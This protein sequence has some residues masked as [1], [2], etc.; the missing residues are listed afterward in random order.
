MNRARKLS[1]VQ[2]V[3]LEAM[4]MGLLA[5]DLKEFLAIS[6]SMAQSFGFLQSRLK[7]EFPKDCRKCGKVYP[8][9]EEF[10]FGT[11]E[12][13]RGTVHYPTLGAE[14]FLHRNCKSPCESTLVAVF[15]DRR[16]D[17]PSGCKRRDI[18]ES[19]LDRLQDKMPLQPA[20]LREFLLGLLIKK[21][22]LME[23]EKQKDAVTV[24]AKPKPG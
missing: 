12:I 20:A 19:C 22:H 23:K 21:I 7:S 17:S 3:D 13:E 1:N 18:F 9:F 14:F 24:L 6:T 5:D 15:A 4:A 11:D 16:D 8:S 2:Y 10:Y